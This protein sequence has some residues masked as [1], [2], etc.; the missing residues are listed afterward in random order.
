MKNLFLLS[1]F[2]LFLSSCVSKEKYYSDINSAKEFAHRQG[3]DEGHKDGCDEGYAKGYAKGYDVGY[4]EG[5]QP[6][7]TSFTPS[8]TNNTPAKY[9][10]QEC[11]G[12]GTKVCY[13]CFD[14]KTLHAY[15]C[16]RCSY[17]GKLK[18]WDCQGTGR[19]SLRY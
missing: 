19:V 14:K 7:K 18:C 4:K 5:Q 13:E 17:I 9:T 1:I 12:L 15:G 2:I 16:S 10:C 11:G 8:K 3:Y 6:N